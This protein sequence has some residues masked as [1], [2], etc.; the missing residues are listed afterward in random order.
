VREVIVTA[1]LLALIVG[2]RGRGDDAVKAVSEDG[3]GFVPWV[4]S[5]IALGMLR[6]TPAEPLVTPILVLAATAWVVRKWPVVKG[7]L[8]ATY[9]TLKG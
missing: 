3:P 5:L 8:A 1:A 6:K 7:D 4:A 2:W 9:D